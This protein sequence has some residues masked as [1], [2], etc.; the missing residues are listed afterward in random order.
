MSGTSLDGLDIA[1]CT[2]VKKETGW[3]YTIEAAATTRYSSSLKKKLS[4][5]HT[6]E[7][8]QLM[9]LHHAYGKYLGEQVKKFIKTHSLRSVDFI[10]SH[11]HT[12]FHQPGKGFTFQ[13]G[14]GHALYAASGMPVIFDFRS[15]DVAKGGQGAPLV[16]IGDQLLFHTHEV[17]LNLGGIA[18]LSREV[19]GKRIAFDICFANMGL[20]Y[21]MQK[22]NKEFD[23]DG[24]LAAQGEVNDKLL[25]SLNKRYNLFRTKRPSLGREDFEKFIQP[26]LDNNAIDLK[27]RLRTFTESIALEIAFALGKSTTQSILL[28]GGGALNSFLLYRLVECCGDENML[29]VPDEE[30]IKFKEALVFAFLGVL[31]FRNETNTLKSVTH[32][33]SNS[34]SGVMIGFK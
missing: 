34:S 29:V 32:A 20:N 1:C 23:K 3:Q 31:R 8:S 21:L 22:I 12:I 2:F 18:N 10:A 24:A 33:I 5:A 6:L 30:V 25:T 15:L 7:G 19:S 28:T 4:T 13:I 11:G 14:E 16:P 26:L 27:D 9:H 17:C